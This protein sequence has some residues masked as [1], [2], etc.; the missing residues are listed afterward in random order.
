MKFKNSVRAG[1]VG[2]VLLAVVL[3]VVAM[4]G[5]SLWV[6]V[7]TK[8]KGRQTVADVLTSVGSQARARLSVAFDHASVSY[9]PQ[10][11][12]LL[13]IKDQASLELWAGDKKDPRYISTYRIEAAS[14]VAGPK[15]REGDKQ[16]PEGLYQ[17]IGLNPNSSFHLSMKLNYPNQFDLTHAAA[18]GR[19][20]PGSDIF[21]HG[22]SVSVGCLAMGDPAIEELFV[23][24]ADIGVDKLSVVIA[25]TDPRGDGLVADGSPVWL[26]VLYQD[27]QNE[28]SY[29]IHQ[30][31]A[32]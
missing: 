9:P 31:P 13:A 16:V 22:K 25:P 6:P 17:V 32:Q 21:I 28:F 2:A 18:E 19:D 14:G 26:A 1:L 8:V 24:A 11:V 29:F 4:Y 27:I 7:L 3:S 23:L 30:E 20:S 5:R 10:Q 12:H 15:L